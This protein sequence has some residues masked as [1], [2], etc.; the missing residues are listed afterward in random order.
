MWIWK[1]LLGEAP[2]KVF[3][4]TDEIQEKITPTPA[5]L[6]D[7]LKEINEIQKNILQD[8]DHLIAP[9]QA[10]HAELTHHHFVQF[11]LSHGHLQQHLHHF[12]AAIQQ[13]FDILIINTSQ[14]EV[15]MDAS[16][17]QTL[18]DI[19]IQKKTLR[20]HINELTLHPHTLQAVQQYL[21]RMENNFKALEREYERGAWLTKELKNKQ[22]VSR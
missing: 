3:E 19:I 16:T 22:F 15:K 10:A 9:E 6:A 13:A 4:N 5:A 8:V 18:T 12:R 7:S 11:A 2:W 1:Q 17:Q 14:K 20:A 21:N